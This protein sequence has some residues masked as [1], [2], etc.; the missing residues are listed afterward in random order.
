MDEIADR[1]HSYATPAIP[2]SPP[3]FLDPRYRRLLSPTSSEPPLFSSDDPPEAADVANYESP[4]Y[5]KKRAG[6]WWETESP[7]G[8]KTKMSRNVDSGVWMASDDPSDC[9]IVG[10]DPEPEPETVQEGVGRGMEGLT[11]VEMELYRYIVQRIESPETYSNNYYGNNSYDLSNRGLKDEALRPLE[12]LNQIILEPQDATIYVPSE[13]QYRSLEP[14]IHLYLSKNSL[15]NLNPSLFRLEY[16]TTL[17]LNDNQITELP[18]QI[19]QLKNLVV[20]D[21]RQNRIQ[22]LP[23]EILDLT[24]G[25]TRLRTLH[26]LGNPLLEPFHDRGGRWT[27]IATKHADT[28]D[29]PSVNHIRTEICDDGK[30]RVYHSWVPRTPDHEGHHKHCPPLPEIE[31]DQE[32]IGIARSR[33]YEGVLMRVSTRYPVFNVARTPPSYFDQLGNLLEESPSPPTS[34]APRTSVIIDETHFNNSE[35]PM[36]WF[37]PAAR[38]KVPSCLTASLMATLQE[39]AP[40]EVRELLVGPDGEGCIPPHVEAILSSAEKNVAQI[41]K[42][43]RNCHCCGKAYVVPRATWIEFWRFN[44]EKQ[45]PIKLQVCSWGCVPDLV[46]KKPEFEYWFE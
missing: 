9:T 15:S 13:A 41:F 37:A 31:L 30:P 5:K 34:G 33:R 40:E 14:Q 8:K 24:H 4:R 2:S 32:M 11:D 23:A 17:I 1:S 29:P 26:L 19:G 39:L 25:K 46:A 38:T 43:F 21:L 44:N 7:P 22:W 3:S 12:L 36:Q 27:E 42:P 6:P 10:M 16:L 18:P 45:M 35:T 20:L 28:L